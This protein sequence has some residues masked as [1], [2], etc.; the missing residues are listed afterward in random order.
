VL[1]VVLLGIAILLC[2]PRVSAAAEVNVITIEGVIDPAMADYLKR[3]L[4]QAQANQAECLI[5]RLNTPGG[6]GKSMNQM[7]DSILNS[8][9]P[10]VVYV[11]PRGAEA[12][13]AGTFITLAAHFAVM[14]PDS[15]IGAAHPMQ[16]IPTPEAPGEEGKQARQQSA[17]IMEKIVNAFAVKARTIAEANGRN[18]DWAEKA[19]RES[20]TATAAEALRLKVIDS[21]QPDMTRLLEWLDGQSVK[22]EGKEVTLHTKGEKAVEIPPSA[23]DRFLHQLADPNLLL[24]LLALAAM[25]ILFELQNPGAILPGVVGG[26]SL[27]LALYSISVL[28]VTTAGLALIGFGLLLLIIDIKVPSHGILSIGGIIA[29]IIGGIMLIDTR[30]SGVVKMSLTIVIA[31]AILI[32][33]FFI[34]AIGAAVRAHLRKPTTGREGML[35]AK[36]KVISPLSEEQQGEVSITGELW[37]ARSQQG[38]LTAGEKVEVVAMEGL[39]LIVRPLPKE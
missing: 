39:T 18:A 10:V 9:L 21:L 6:L 24:I 5:I 3:A 33:G 16:L 34:F 12:F 27:L 4:Q 38:N 26:I 37:R 2:S 19:V 31:T 1:I 25:G 29:F 14:H 28:P 13:S 35:G 30:Y 8:P 32:A 11:S 20:A 36:G 7:I 23:K 15:T 17:A 22:V